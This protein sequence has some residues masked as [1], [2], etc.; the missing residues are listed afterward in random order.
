MMKQDEFDIHSLILETLKPIGIPVY[1][2]S[3]KEVNPPLIVFNVV[4]E[5][6]KEFWDDEE[7][8]TQYKVT[9]NIFSRG[10]FLNYK[11]EVLNRM[12][13][14]GFIRTDIP[15]CIYQ[16]DIELFNQ[17]MFFSYFKENF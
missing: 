6:G 1:F 8:V 16:E 15:E 12:K 7:Q 11:K 13:S 4:T 10:N 9:I 5:K 2:V 14:I 17:P 3:R